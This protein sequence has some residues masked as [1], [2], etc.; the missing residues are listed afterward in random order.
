MGYMVTQEI[1]TFISVSFKTFDKQDIYSKLGGFS[2]GYEFIR[3]V[4]KTDR[5][6]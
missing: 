6:S 4:L 5:K 1:N 2:N 3:D